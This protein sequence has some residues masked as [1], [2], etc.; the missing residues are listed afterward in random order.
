MAQFSVL[1][2]VYNGANFLEEALQSIADQTLDD[3]QVVVSNNASTDA[4]ADILES[5]R[6]RLNLRVITQPETLPM[7]AHFNAILGAVDSEFY[8]LLC[9]DDYLA[10]PDAL[11]LARNALMANPDMAA[12][13]CNLLY[14]S[15]Q[16]KK[17]AERTFKRDTIFSA[18][19]AGQKSIRTARNQFGIPIG[20]RR[21][22]LGDLRYDTRFPYMMDVDLS[23]A[24]SRHQSVLHIPKTLIANRYG[25]TNMT[26]SLLSTALKEHL[27]LA[28]KY[29]IKMNFIDHVRLRM[30]SYLV[31]LQK[32]VFGL[33][34]GFVS[35][36][37]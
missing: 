28:D 14:V 3:V 33:Y 35:W 12:V 25:N 11:T 27:T 37:G 22:A 16:R 13:Y 31:G 23:W 7:Q 19:E 21:S 9:H 26:W 36:R 4:T 30:V 20:I 17:L 29:G 2:P 8:M 32:R 24:I 15:P 5:W 1:I 18:D 34:Q 6:D 10:D